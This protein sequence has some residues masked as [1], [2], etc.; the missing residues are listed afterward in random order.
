[1]WKLL[2]YSLLFLLVCSCTPGTGSVVQAEGGNLYAGGFSMAELE[3]YR[4]LKVNRPW[5]N[6]EDRRVL[7]YILADD[8]MLVPDSL[9]V[10]PVIRT[11]VSK[12][13]A[14]SSGNVA[15]ISALDESAS[16]QAVSGS[17]FIYDSLIRKRIVNGEIADVGYDQQL[18]YE[19]IVDLDPDVLFLYGV[20]PSVET[21]VR[22]LQ[23]LGITAV[24]CSDYLE[25]DPLG[26]SEWIRFLAA[27]YNKG[28]MADS[29]FGTIAARYNRVK[30]LVQNL[31][32]KPKVLSGLPWK[33]TWYVPGGRSFAARFIEDAG[34]EYLWKE[35]ESMEAL[36]LNLEAV[37][38][39]ALAADIWINTGDAGSLAAVAAYDER[40]SDIPV[41]RSGDLYNNNL[42]TNSFGGN[43]YWE[44][45][46]MHPDLILA[47]L[48]E[49]FHP[50]MVEGHR[51]TY[52]KKLK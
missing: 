35:T 5:Q 26:K 50:G 36:P 48:A 19:L 39:R 2:L 40:F 47:D 16:L 25:S 28:A 31:E 52:Y 51:W 27:F 29:L 7:T 8:P 32:E 20:D 49:I 24:I 34:G 6:N 10:F 12:V 3:N 46:V 43:D 22:K 38:A 4:I 18:N 30:D 21:T 9:R 11:P 33:D 14:L 44:S 37:Y 23:E 42:R 45:G 15:M 17:G 41:F 13:I 1:M